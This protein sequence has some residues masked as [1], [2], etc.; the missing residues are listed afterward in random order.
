MGD[1]GMLMNA[2]AKRARSAQRP[3]SGEIE[4]RRAS[5]LEAGIMTAARAWAAAFEA[6]Q[7]QEAAPGEG[8]ELALHDA[9]A[10][11]TALKRAELALY[12]AILTSELVA[13]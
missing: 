9:L 3:T 6:R 10:E 5:A 7:R 4:V 2:D 11:I 1:E 8:A 13:K 12:Q